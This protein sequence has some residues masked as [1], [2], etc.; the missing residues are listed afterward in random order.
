[1]QLR[2]NHIPLNAY[3]HRI[4]KAE[5]KKCDS[6]WRVR[7][8]VVTETVVHFL[9]ECPSFDYE[10]HDLDRKLGAQSRNLRAILANKD[11]VKELIRYIGR[12]RRL[13]K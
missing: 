6:C 3:L 11:H 2:T 7:H 10:R 12:T 13:K 5:S 4:G 1:I 8:E 9:F